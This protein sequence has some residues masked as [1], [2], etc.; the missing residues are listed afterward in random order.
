MDNQ[1]PLPSKYIDNMFIQHIV[2]ETNHYVC[3]METKPLPG[4]WQTSWVWQPKCH[5]KWKPLTEPV[6]WLACI[7]DF[8]WMALH[9]TANIEEL[10]SSHWIWETETSC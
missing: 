8:M 4:W 2:Q 10:W 6:L 7:L 1:A 5:E 9:W 3:K